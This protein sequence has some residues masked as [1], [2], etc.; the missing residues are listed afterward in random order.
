M[1]GVAGTG[2]PMRPGTN[3]GASEGATDPFVAATKLLARGFLDRG[4]EL[5]RGR[6]EPVLLRLGAADLDQG[7][8]GE[9]RLE[10]RLRRLG[11]RVHRIAAGDRAGHV[12][13]PDEAGGAGEA[14]RTWQF[15][16]D[17]P[18]AAEPAELLV[19]PPDALIAVRAPADGH[20][21]DLARGPPGAGGGVPPPGQG[22]VR[23]NRDHH[24][25]QRREQLTRLLSGYRDARAAPNGRAGPRSWPRPP[26]SGCP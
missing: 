15:R 22:T 4:D 3:R 2:K 1:A 18:A 9:S 10:E 25:G 13:G 6:E 12:L 8:V 20:L 11:D 5:R 7:E 24:V 23:L 16:V 21:A 19:R 17:L 14:R 26:G